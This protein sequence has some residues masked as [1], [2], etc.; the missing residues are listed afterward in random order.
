MSPDVQESWDVR[1]TLISHA[2]AGEGARELLEGLAEGPRTRAQQ[3]LVRLTSSS[4][5]ARRARLA[6]TFETR[7]HGEMAFQR[8]LRCAGAPLRRALIDAAPARWRIALPRSEL[9]H[10]SGPS[11]AGLVRFAERLI[12]EASSLRDL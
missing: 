3:A 6:R 5:S 12:W 8:L 7:A 10:G 1:V 11:P 9:T 4:R 2:L